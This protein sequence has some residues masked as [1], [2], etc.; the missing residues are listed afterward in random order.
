MYKNTDVV[1]GLEADTV[2]LLANDVPNEPL[3]ESE[4]LGAA[5]IKRLVFADQDTLAI[6]RLRIAALAK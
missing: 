4:R 2:V 5:G 3:S 1:V 6:W